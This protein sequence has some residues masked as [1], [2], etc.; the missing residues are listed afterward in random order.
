MKTSDFDYTLPEGLIAQMPIEPRDRSR[1]MVLDRRRGSIEHRQFFEIIEYLRE[2]DVLVL[3]DSR[4]IPARL[5]GR[6]NSGGRVE[7]LL[8]RRREAGVWEAL[9][10]PA[11]RLQAGAKVAIASH[12]LPSDTGLTAEI[13]AAE[14]GGVRLVRFS[15]ESGLATAGEVALPPYIH[16]PLANPGRYQTVYA[17]ADGSVAAPTAGL[18]FTPG[19][20]GA[21]RGRGVRCLFT[22]LHVGL[23]TFRPVKEADPHD[24]AIHREYGV[25]DG[26][27]AAELTRARESGRRVICVGTTTARLLEQAATASPWPGIVAFQGWVELFI[28]PGHRFR[29][30]DALVTNFHLPRSTLLMLVSAFAGKDIIDKAYREAIEQRYRFYSFGDAMLVL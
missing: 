11:R 8:L 13:V 21:I 10:K 16:T 26:E 9:V 25:L 1:L 28:L 20:L 23:D 6:K 29:A 27:V 22:T 30:I 18:H 14:T 4:V 19:L 24:H 17:K 5:K 12:H 3:N 2:G 7:I 15:G